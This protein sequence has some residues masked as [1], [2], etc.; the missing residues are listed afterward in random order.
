MTC[1]IKNIILKMKNMQ[2][3]NKL[4][5]Y[6]Q[7][8]KELNKKIQQLRAEILNYKK[9]SSQKSQ[10]TSS[11]SSPNV[12]NDNYFFENNIIDNS[13]K[14]YKILKEMEINALKKPRQRRYSLF[15]KLFSMGLLLISFNGYKYLRNILP[16]P[17]PNLLMNNY[18]LS[19]NFEYEVLTN[20]SNINSLTQKYKQKENISENDIIKVVLA[21]DAISFN[22]ILTIDKSGTVYG[23]INTEKID[24][25]KL[26]KL[27][28]DFTAFEKFVQKRKK[29]IVT[30]AF[31]YQVQP[32]LPFYNSFVIHV[33]PSTQGKGTDRE[34]E[35]L[36]KIKE[37]IENQ[38]FE[39]ISFAFDGDS[40]YNKLHDNMY[41]GYSN[42]VKNNPKFLNFSNINQLNVISD[43]LHLL[44]RGRYRLTS[45]KIHCGLTNYSEIINLSTIQN[46]FKYPEITFSNSQITKMHDSLATR[47]FSFYSLKTIIESN[48]TNY[49]SYFLPLCLLNI[50]LSEKDIT[51]IERINLLEISFYYCL[52][53]KEESNSTSKLLPSKRTKNNQDVRLFDNIFLMQLS[54]TLFTYLKIL[55]S[56]RGSINLNRLSSN[57]LEHTFGLIRM[58]SRYSHIYS[59]AIKSLGK[60]ELLKK[61]SKI[62]QPGE[63]INGRKS[64]YGKTIF[65]NFT[66]FQS[67]FNYDPREI[68]ICLHFYF[69]LPITYADIIC[70]N[71]EDFL[72]LSKE[73]INNFQL[74]LLN[75]YYRCYPT[76]RNNKLTSNEIIMKKSNIIDRFA[77]KFANE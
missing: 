70:D 33:H 39:V 36:F 45:S 65:N 2:N 28:Q 58:R 64:Y 17:S 77:N 55:Y 52:I 27:N 5:Q 25:V 10:N 67:V 32:L 42:I 34:V 38:N 9:N 40:V 59:N 68:A 22:P 62:I 73:I 16:L 56:Y 48:N 37:I 3:L 18:K 35:L 74:N 23:T 30:D 20:L 49:L 51:N 4:R 75:I 31:V 69:N 76:Q 54:N 6:S 1:D 46:I 12:F 15:F 14:D 24:D 21:V 63:P 29:F 60:V 50:A 72:F 53:L 41:N 26:K 44:K 61:I 7:K 66:D 43:P 11:N 13:R 19:L 71:M 8:N 47:L 57:P